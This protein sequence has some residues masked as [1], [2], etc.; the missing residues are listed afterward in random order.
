MADLIEQAATGV[1]ERLPTETTDVQQLLQA[2][3]NGT[4][5]RE[6]IDAVIALTERLQA[7]KA[8][9]AYNVAMAG[10]HQELEPV[11]VDMA[12]PQTRSKY[13][14]LKA[15]NEAV[16]PVCGRH[17]LFVSFDTEDTDKPDTVR[18]VAKAKHVVGHEEHFHVDMPADGKGA[19]GGEVMTR[20]HAVGSAL[21]YGQRRLLQLI[22]NLAPDQDDDGN[23]AGRTAP[24]A[25]EGYAQ[26]FDALTSV[27]LNGTED[28]QTAWNATPSAPFKNHLRQHHPDAWTALKASAKA[29]DD[30]RKKAAKK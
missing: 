10:A 2:L 1:P 7:R 11:R 5:N 28:L 23:G 13:M 4:I 6:S 8:L 3:T 9:A 14:S 30:A 22:F 12:N 15:V 21:T 27:A 20:T 16:V 26:W 29:V 24:G 19:K 17:G 25:P 18:I